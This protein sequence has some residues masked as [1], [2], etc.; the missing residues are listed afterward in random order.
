MTCCAAINEDTGRLF[1]RFAAW[2]RWRFRLFGF[3]RT[4]RQLLGGIGKAG[5][6]GAMLLEIGCGPGYLHRA[7]LRRGAERATGVDLSAGMLEIARAGALAEGLAARTDYL[8]GDFTQMADQVGE[9]DVV[10]L[11]KVICCYPDWLAL[12]DRSLGKARRCYALTIPRD[13]ALTRAAIEAM[14]WGLRGMGCCYQPFI[15]GPE[16]IDGRIRS[17][18]FRLLD[19][20]LTPLWLTRT[21]TRVQAAPKSGLEATSA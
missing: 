4:Q 7:L 10:I 13:R 14:R 3:E 12:V 2:H 18:G 21:Y 20:A 6:R 19:E 15:H 17:G 9:A 1:S 16:E 11:D 5:A 8:Q